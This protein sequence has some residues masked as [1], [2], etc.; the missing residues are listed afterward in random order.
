MIVEQERILPTNLCRLLVEAL[1]RV[2]GERLHRARRECADNGGCDRRG[3]GARPRADA[4]GALCS[5]L[6][7]WRCVSDVVRIRERVVGHDVARQ[8]A[9]PRDAHGGA[10][11]GLVHRV[12]VACG[13]TRNFLK[14]G[15]GIDANREG[16]LIFGVRVSVRG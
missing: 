13:R 4:G 3:T 11:A 12:V 1:A 16:G 14:K 5:D 8:P 15:S 10:P 6:N 9:A 7:H 2:E